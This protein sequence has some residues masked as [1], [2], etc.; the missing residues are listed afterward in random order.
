MVVV[1]VIL[2]VFVLLSVYF[3]FR[4]EKLQRQVT[5]Q[6]KE[7]SQTKKDNKLLS[8]ATALLA[9][10]YD[11]FAKFRFNKIK[12]RIDQN[13]AD[14]TAASKE[15]EIITPLIVNYAAI[16]RACI[17]SKGQLKPTAKKCF[18][19]YDANSFKIFVEFIG[20]QDNHVKRMWSS[21]NLNG[22]VSLVE[23]LLLNLEK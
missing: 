23:T 18:D 22:F 6:K 21:N 13:D 2:L 16:Y 12:E 3:F 9:S 14:K 7:T 5:L 4:V 20:K 10:R 19:S 11:E 17:T 1:L 8:D 15:V